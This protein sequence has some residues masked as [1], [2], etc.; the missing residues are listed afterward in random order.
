[1]VPF[2]SDLALS[3][4]LNIL[5][6]DAHMYYTWSVKYCIHY[7]SPSA[8][9]VRFG[10]AESASS[11]SMQ[12]PDCMLN[13]QMC[14]VPISQYPSAFCVRFCAAQ[15]AESA[16]MWYPDGMLNSLQNVQVN[17]VEWAI[18]LHGMYKSFRVNGFLC[19]FSQR[20]LLW[21]VKH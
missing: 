11:T 10:G 9:H 18:A 1:M 7:Q 16:S 2:V 19:K 12:C 4:L 14:I 15:S 21:T 20:C 8:F 17:L 3:N 13:W 6:H 5:Q